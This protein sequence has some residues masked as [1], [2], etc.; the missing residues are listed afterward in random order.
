MAVT[1]T[2]L[3][4][5]VHWCSIP[6][7]A[8]TFQI[9]L[10]ENLLSPNFLMSHNR[11]KRKKTF[12]V[13]VYNLPPSHLTDLA[14]LQGHCRRRLFLKKKV[15]R[16]MKNYIYQNNNSTTIIFTFRK[17]IEGTFQIIFHLQLTQQFRVDQEVQAGPGLP[18]QQIGKKKHFISLLE[19]KMTT[20]FIW[21][22]AQT[23]MQ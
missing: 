11:C 18:V 12:F 19:C 9:Q 14:I 16:K 1:S 3:S 23:G 22:R 17:K 20:N 15:K 8:R 10:K 21:A 5:M 6:A 13:Y 4:P 2:S 7:L